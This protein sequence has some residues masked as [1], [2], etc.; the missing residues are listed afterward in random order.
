[1]S[2]H[3]QQH[4]DNE[5]L[6]MNK[7]KWNISMVAALLFLILTTQA[8]SSHT[9]ETPVRE[10]GAEA[11]ARQVPASE[12]SQEWTQWGGPHR[13][14]ISDAT[15]LADSWPAAGPRQLWSR[16]LGNGHSTIIV[17]NGRLYTMYRPEADGL[18]REEFAT[19][20]SVIALDAT[21]GETLWEHSYASEPLNFRFGAGPHATPLVVGDR[22]FTAGT[23]KQIHAFDK[24]TGKLL[25]SHDLVA[26]YGAPRTLIRPAVTAG[27]ASSPLAYGDTVIVTAGGDN[28]SVMAFRQ[29]NG[30]L[31]WTSGDF[32]I[33]PSSPILIDLA[34]QVQLVVVGGQT[35]NGLNPDTGEIL[36]SHPH[37][38]DGDMNN[39]TPIWGDD[40]LLFVSSAY[41]GGSRGLRLDKTREG[42]K[43]KEEW[44]T[45]DMLVMYG[46]TIRLGDF[47]YGSSGGFGPA[48]ITALD[49]RSGT[50]TWKER[51]LSRAHLLYADGK[52]I[53]LDEDGNLVLAHVS[54]TGMTVHSRAEVLT[55][56][57][58][59]APTL[60]GTTLFLRDRLVIKALDIGPS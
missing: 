51:G 58:W 49:L 42:T 52:L 20:E 45:R 37:D 6:Q 16:P 46:T 55:G 9:Q 43:V 48:F 14:F 30:D 10:L 11:K 18:R 36:W 17:E 56:R 19:S 25:W 22:L 35:I 41:N 24:Q 21:N 60:A 1:M 29:D 47:I 15:G 57:S 50:T 27:Y 44:F 28:Q 32:L 5:R 33:S 38:T 4:T 7:W 40:N 8:A 23:N 12:T 31:V 39:T 26:E 13:N 53:L 2:C 54:P 3:H 34:G 59:T